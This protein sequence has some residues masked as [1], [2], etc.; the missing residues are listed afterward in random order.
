MRMGT[1]I[2]VG[3]LSLT[4]A[5]LISI[6]TWEGFKDEAYIPV[7]GDVPTIGFGSTEGVKLGD[8][9]SVPD[10]LNRLE[11]D[12]RVAED[13]VRSCVT[14]PLTQGEMDAYTSLAYNIGK[15]NFCGSTLVKKLNAR[16]YRGLAR[17]SS[18]GTLL[19]EKASRGLS[20]DGRMNTLGAWV[21]R[22]EL[23]QK[24]DEC[25]LKCTCEIVE[26]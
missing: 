20:I 6:A 18:A 13:A 16:D 8:T 9:I 22:S 24:A 1:R 11:K 19:T 3:S 2:A 14:V 5:G 25:T 15:K 10:A 26:R 21:W 23:Y 12:V 7:E 4:A 17:R